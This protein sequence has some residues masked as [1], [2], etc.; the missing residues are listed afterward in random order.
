MVPPLEAR[1]HLLGGR[2]QIE[3]YRHRQQ[4]LGRL[5]VQQQRLVTPLADRFLGRLVEQRM[6]RSTFMSLTRPFT[7]T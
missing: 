4:E 7:P 2:L 3:F 6:P 1:R 5:S